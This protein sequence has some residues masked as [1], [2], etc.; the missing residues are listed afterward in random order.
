[1]F[2]KQVLDSNF[3][4]TEASSSNAVGS[5]HHHGTPII[6]W[7]GL[8][9][10]RQRRER[11]LSAGVNS[12]PLVAKHAPTEICIDCVKSTAKLVRDIVHL[13]ISNNFDT[14]DGSTKSAVSR[15]CYVDMNA[16]LGDSSKPA[17]LHVI[18][19]NVPFF[20][21]GTIVSILDTFMSFFRA[22]ENSSAV[23]QHCTVGQQK[24]NVYMDACVVRTSMA[25]LYDSDTMPISIVFIFSVHPAIAGQEQGTL[26]SSMKRTCKFTSNLRN[27]HSMS[28]SVANMRIRAVHLLGASAC[29][30]AQVHKARSMVEA[31]F[32]SVA[33]RKIIAPSQ[34]EP[35]FVSKSM[36]AVDKRTVITQDESKLSEQIRK[37][38]QHCDVVFRVSYKMPMYIYTLLKQWAKKRV[39]LDTEIDAQWKLVDFFAERVALSNAHQEGTCFVGLVYVSDISRQRCDKENSQAK[40]RTIPT[41]IESAPSRLSVS[42]SSVKRQRKSYL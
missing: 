32:T 4:R 9:Y 10:D 26:I 16:T 8:E 38:I 33:G 36:A 31:M 28:T 34:I 25:D 20:S 12:N 7:N 15:H 18:I 13:N 30:G 29:E 40:R 21:I 3:R 22:A 41:L 17:S 39:G 42:I 11:T 5:A 14:A 37:R 24:P 6:N 23:L 19:G 35:I 2:R 27:W 1:M